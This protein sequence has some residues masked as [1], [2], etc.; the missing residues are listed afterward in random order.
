MKQTIAID[1]DDTLTDSTETVRRLVNEKLGVNLSREAYL[2]PDQYWGYWD[3][4]WERNGIGERITYADI[5]QQFIDGLHPPFLPDAEAAIAQLAKRYDVIVVTSRDQVREVTTRQWLEEH[6]DGRIKD[7]CFTTSHDE[8]KEFTKGQLCRQLGASLLVDD[9]VEHCQ[10]A[11]DEG[12]EAILFGAYG[13]QHHAPAGMR[14]R[15][16]WREVM[17]VLD[18][19]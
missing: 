14:R 19:K 1:I 9:N 15:A 12:L 3:R 16:N 4:V 17:G 13:W 8:T 7:V 6:F 11:L 2:V 10:S 5:L 18:E